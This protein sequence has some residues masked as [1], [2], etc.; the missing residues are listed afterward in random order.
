MKTNKILLLVVFIVAALGASAQWTTSSTNTYTTNFVGVDLTSNPVP[1]QP[2][3]KFAV[4]NEVYFGN[5]I[6]CVGNV[7]AMA[8][9]GKWTLGWGALSG[10]NM[11]F[12]SSTNAS[13]PG[14]L[15][16]T[17]GGAPST[18]YVEF[19]Q[20]NGSGGF[21][22]CLFVNNNGNVGIGTASPTSKLQVVG[23]ITCTSVTS[24]GALSCT[25]LSANGKITTKEV[26]VTLTGWPDYV[27]G[28]DYKLTPLTEVEQYIGEHKHLP[29]VSSAKE[30]E[31]NGVQLGEMNKVLMQKVEELTLY[32]IELQKQV[33]E[34][35]SK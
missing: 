29:G 34:L 30:L 24:S 35:K 22:S 28:K 18:G 32:V 16:F 11:E 3:I 27:F 12:Y 31:S 17:F 10:A 7:K 14:Q 33:D 9:S 5:R 26:E 8:S 13:K 4:A 15:N 21:T 23:G 2:L 1:A 19:R 20:S 25:S 6:N